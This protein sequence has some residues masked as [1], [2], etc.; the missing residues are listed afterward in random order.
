[1]EDI[2]LW[3]ERDISH[4]SVERV[5]LPDS[6]ILLDYMLNKFMDIVGHLIVHEERMLENLNKS[7]GIVFSGRLLLTLIDKGLTRNEAYDKVQ[8]AAFNAKKEGID[9]K[10]AL[11]I[12]DGIRSILDEKEIESV[13]DLRYHL[14]NIDRIFRRVGI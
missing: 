9:F 5:I 2:V 14:R 7:G 3:H 13:F 8:K 6:T 12:D 11:L 10:Q 1:M 4:S